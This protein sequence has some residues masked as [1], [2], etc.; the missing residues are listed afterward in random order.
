MVS[1]HSKVWRN[2]K[3]F[4][5]CRWTDL[6]CGTMLL[7]PPPPRLWD[8]ITSRGPFRET[9]DSR[10]KT[11]EYSFTTSPWRRFRHTPTHTH[12]T[13][14]T[15]NNASSL[16]CVSPLSPWLGWFTGMKSGIWDFTWWP[17]AML[18]F[19]TALIHCNHILPPPTNL[20]LLPLG[21]TG[22]LITEDRNRQCL[23]A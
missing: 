5:S 6:T 18:A 16:G 20:L 4:M 21:L 23:S 9:S 22:A 10:G 19:S 11:P 13:T 3:S 7:W 12:K 14:T 1:G 17:T 15:Q 8:A 2:V